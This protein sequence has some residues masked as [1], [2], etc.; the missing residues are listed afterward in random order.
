ML[1]QK[2]RPRTVFQK[3]RRDY[4]TARKRKLKLFPALKLSPLAK[5]IIKKSIQ[6]ALATHFEHPTYAERR[7][8]MK[9]IL[10]TSIVE[11]V[12]ASKIP[13][14][15]RKILIQLSE[16]FAQHINEKNQPKKILERFEITK[17]E[18][19]LVKS[20][21]PKSIEK[22]R[23]TLHDIVSELPSHVTYEAY[24]RGPG[25]KGK[26][27]F[28]LKHVEFYIIHDIAHSVTNFIQFT[29]EANRI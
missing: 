14:K 2:A 5:K 1:F 10:K 8:R 4:S 17:E 12:K 28:F 7:A 13:K 21:A 20:L 23:E 26:L 19:Q 22:V 15:D 27:E 6:P 25:E 9:E 11:A 24:A 29:Q 3:N 18:R 16:L